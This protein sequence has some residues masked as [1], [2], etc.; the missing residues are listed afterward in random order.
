MNQE[1]DLP[2]NYNGFKVSWEFLCENT[3]KPFPH[4]T[5]W[6]YFL[7]VSVALSGIGI[8][9][10]LL[11]LEK[12]NYTPLKIAFLLFTPP[13]INST[14]FQ[15][16]LTNRVQKNCKAVIAGIAIIANI[17]FLYLFNQK[18]DVFSCGLILLTGFLVLVALWLNWFQSSLNDDLYDFKPNPLGP[19]PKKT[20]LPETKKRKVQM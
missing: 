10:E 7:L 1:S 12:G 9:Y 18:N 19:D 13:L 8:I 11:N 6:L 14:L 20:K 15:I 2:N 3:K 17:I 5:F 16:I 4:T